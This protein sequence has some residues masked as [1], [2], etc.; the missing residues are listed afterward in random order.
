MKLDDLTESL[1]EKATQFER[2]A[3]IIREQ[4]SYRNQTWMRSADRLGNDVMNFVADVH[5]HEQTGRKCDMTWA[6][7]QT[8]VQKC[9][10]KNTMGYNY[11]S[12]SSHG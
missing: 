2:A 5:H 6:E 8:K 1:L 12:T 9:R 4:V 10:L 3:Q 7:G 11:A